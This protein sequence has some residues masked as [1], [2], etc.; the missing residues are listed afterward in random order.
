MNPGE[1]IWIDFP[2]VVQT[3]RRP[4]VILSSASYHST[5]PDVIVGLITSQTIKASAP[6][7]HVLQ[8]WQSA[9]LR[10]PS[11]FRAFLV[12]LPQS[13]IVST[14]GTLSPTDWTQ[15]ASR[16]KLAIGLT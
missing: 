1:V 5:R 10:V 6:T 12:T 13:S 11:A 16:V 3:K 8:D 7:D 2:G 14:M 9:G 4:A 15:V